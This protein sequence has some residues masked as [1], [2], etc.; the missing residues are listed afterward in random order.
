[1]S[2]ISFIIKVTIFG[3]SHC[4]RKILPFCAD[5]GAEGIVLCV[6]P[7]EWRGTLSLACSSKKQVYLALKPENSALSQVLSLVQA[8]I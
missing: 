1:V 5:Q 7:A 6:A 2:N 3:A 4:D 8:V